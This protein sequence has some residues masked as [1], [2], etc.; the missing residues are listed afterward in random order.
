MPVRT[1]SNK[2]ERILPIGEKTLSLP[3]YVPSFSEFHM[4]GTHSGRIWKPFLSALAGA[5]LPAIMLSIYDLNY[6][7]RMSLIAKKAVDRGESL[8]GV[9]G[10]PESTILFLDSGGLELA[11]NPAE[12]FSAEMSYA[13]GCM[14]GGDVIVLLDYPGAN[15]RGRDLRT[16]EFEIA[17]RLS[18]VHR[19]PA[20]LAAVAHGAS[21]AELA[22]SV[23]RYA[24]LS[25]LG[26]VCVPKKEV[27]RNTEA[28]AEALPHLRSAA[29]DCVLHILGEGSPAMWRL[30]SGLGA[31]S[32]DATSWSR[33]LFLPKTYRRVDSWDPPDE[34]CDCGQC[35]GESMSRTCRTIASSIRHNWALFNQE[36]DAI[37]ALRTAVSR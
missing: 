7:P 13:S 28:S 3:V 27:G 17:S 5:N 21:L 15:G 23:H 26:V 25:G 32:F 10:L 31:D 14:L 30:L 8:L 19:G 22:E 34:I 6:G 18:R 16:E 37:R 1:G 12:N 29:G 33:G 9:L 11:E 36:M 35:D 24:S 2:H 20:A 4:G